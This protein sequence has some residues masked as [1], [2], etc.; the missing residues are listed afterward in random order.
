[1]V[2]SGQ[3]TMAILPTGGGK[4][5]LYQLPAMYL[6]GVTLVVSPLIAL[7]DDQVWQLKKRGITAYAWHSGKSGRDQDL[8]R[9]NLARDKEASL[10]YVSPERLETEIFREFCQ[11]F[12]LRLLAVDEAHCISQWGHDFRPAYRNILQFREAYPGIP[13]IALTA[14]ATPHVEQD[15][16]RKSTRLNSSHVKIS[17]AVFC[18][19]K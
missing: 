11:Q 12:D 14:T 9:S 1:S 4:S 15:I 5:L 13:V 10:L 18:L 8:L 6:G 7:M 16:D 3:D 17:Y 19:K 2:C